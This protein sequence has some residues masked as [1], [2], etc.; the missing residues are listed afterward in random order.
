MGPARGKVS[1]VGDVLDRVFKTTAPA[2]AAGSIDAKVLD[3]RQLINTS[4]NQNT[5][6][7]LIR[8]LLRKAPDD[9]VHDLFILSG[10]NDQAPNRRLRWSRH[11]AYRFGNAAPLLVLLLLLDVCRDDVTSLGGCLSYRL[12]RLVAGDLAGVLPRLDSAVLAR[13]HKNTQ[14]HRGTGH[15]PAT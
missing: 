11:L 14:W 4:V 1:H 8:S 9:A 7:L 3:V 6:H 2:K 10:F 12:P 13:I 5:D 15:K